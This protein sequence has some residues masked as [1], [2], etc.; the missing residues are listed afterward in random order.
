[1]AK[2]FTALFYKRTYRKRLLWQL[3]KGS[4]DGYQGVEFAGFWCSRFRVKKV[5]D[6]LG[7]VLVEA[8]LELTPL[9]KKSKQ[10]RDYNLELGTST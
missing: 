8:T 6:D 1:M 4:Q 3:G 7:I 10:G 5:L 2:W 9:K